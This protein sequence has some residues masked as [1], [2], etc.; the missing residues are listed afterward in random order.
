MN[1]RVSIDRIINDN[2]PRPEIFLACGRQD[3]LLPGNLVYRDLLKN[4]GF[5][6]TWKCTNGG[7]TWDFWDKYIE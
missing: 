4:K 5:K 2:S 7:H 1:P 3:F 6:V